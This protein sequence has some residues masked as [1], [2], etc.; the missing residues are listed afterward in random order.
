[1][2]YEFQDHVFKLAFRHLP[3]PHAYARLRHEPAY[4]LRDGVDSL[5]AVMDEEDLPAALEL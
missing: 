1:M 3:V 4:K 2:A 5:D